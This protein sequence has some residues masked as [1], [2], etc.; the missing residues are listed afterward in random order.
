MANSDDMK[1]RLAEL[2]AYLAHQDATMQKL[3]DNAA[4]QW[5]VIENLE[6][7]VQVLRERVASLITGE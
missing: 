6:Q 1:Q 5:D 2:E 4:K 7:T 3:S